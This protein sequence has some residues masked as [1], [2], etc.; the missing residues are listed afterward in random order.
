MGTMAV[1]GMPPFSIFQ[2]EFRILSAAFAADRGWAALLLI[3]G[4][5]TIFAGF[6][7]H[8]SK[9]NLGSPAQ[10][11]ARAAECPWKL[12]AMGLV[13]VAT[14]A[15]GLWVPGPLY[16]LLQESARLIGGAS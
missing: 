9:L 11:S 3:A 16:Q 15:L 7:V 12:T 1:T 2:S 10:G 8:M 4:L 14:I 5:V 13:A 6:L